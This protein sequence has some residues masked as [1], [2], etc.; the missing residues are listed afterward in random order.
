MPMHYT[1]LH[2][3]HHADYEVA[4]EHIY[5]QLGKLDI[6]LFDRDVMVA[7]YVRPIQNPRTGLSIT[8]AAQVEDTIQGKVC[9]VL[10]LGPSAF[11]CETQSDYDAIYGENG[12]P[13]VGD[14]LMVRASAGDPVSFCGDNAETVMYEDRHGEEHKAYAWDAGW[15]CRI[16]RDDNFM[17]RVLNPHSTV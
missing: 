16:I 6:E 15:P 4:K 14:W 3:W 1:Q 17:A 10:K 9:L 12:P 7:V 11:Q 5:R 2:K 13:K 8:D